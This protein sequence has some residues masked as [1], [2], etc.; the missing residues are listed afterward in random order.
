MVGAFVKRIGSNPAR[1]LAM[2]SS[3]AATAS[4]FMRSN[5]SWYWVFTFPD[6]LY[7]E[8]VLLALVAEGPSVA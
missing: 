4:R 5:W 1:S 3:R 6:T 7:V 8:G 2:A